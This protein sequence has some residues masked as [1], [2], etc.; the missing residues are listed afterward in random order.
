[1]KYI[2]IPC[3]SNAPD[4]DHDCVVL[5]VDEQLHETLAAN[6]RAFDM[7]KLADPKL[8]AHEYNGG[9]VHYLHVNNGEYLDAPGEPVDIEEHLGDIG[10]YDPFY[11]TAV[12]AVFLKVVAESFFYTFDGRVEKHGPSEIYQTDPFTL[13]ELEALCP[14]LK[15]K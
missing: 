8:Y 4:R 11:L 7:R 14:T 1:M 10:L 6:K 12:P 15:S 13:Q 5:K 9:P 2:L 3:V